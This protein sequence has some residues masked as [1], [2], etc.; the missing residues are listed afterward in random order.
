MYVKCERCVT[1]IDAKNI[2]ELNSSVCSFD[3]STEFSTLEYV[4]HSM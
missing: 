3:L 2:N 1:I 4:C